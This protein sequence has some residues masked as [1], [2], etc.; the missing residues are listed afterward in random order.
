MSQDSNPYAL[1]LTCMCVGIIILICGERETNAVSFW[2]AAVTVLGDS[3]LSFEGGE[4][5]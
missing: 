5:S 4:E 1:E 2:A 3:S